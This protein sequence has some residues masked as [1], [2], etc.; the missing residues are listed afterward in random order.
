MRLRDS[1]FEAENRRAEMAIESERATKFDELFRQRKRAARQI[2]GRVTVTAQRGHLDAESDIRFAREQ[3]LDE[4]FDRLVVVPPPVHEYERLS[5]TT[6]ARI[7]LAAQHFSREALAQ[8]ANPREQADA[9]GQGSHWFRPSDGAEIPSWQ[10][11]TPEARPWEA[12]E[13]EVGWQGDLG[14]DG[15]RWA[16]GRAVMYGADPD[17][18]EQPTEP[19]HRTVLGSVKTAIFG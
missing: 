6:K 1:D 7:L 2:A 12:I 15:I 19:A 11:N 3:Q 9:W 13:I 8:I 18:D 16:R 17:S 14:L 10:L 4:M 5:E